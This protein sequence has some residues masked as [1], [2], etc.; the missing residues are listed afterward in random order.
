[1]TDENTTKR[2][3][4]LKILIFILSSI[5]LLF[6][7][8]G[9]IFWGGG[10]ETNVTI[11]NVEPGKIFFPVKVDVARKGDLIQWI[12]TSGVANRYKKLI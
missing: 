11:Q 2:K 4:R 3:S 6:L 8:A 9:I 12:N 1:M 10:E 7:I 5:F